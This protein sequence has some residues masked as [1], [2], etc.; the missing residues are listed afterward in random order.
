MK[1]HPC[2]YCGGGTFLAEGQWKGARLGMVVC[3]VCGAHGPYGE[4]SAEYVAKWNVVASARKE[5]EGEE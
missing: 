3:K 4:K 2:P 5:V 1:T